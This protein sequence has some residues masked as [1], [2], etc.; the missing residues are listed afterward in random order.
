MYVQKLLIN[1]YHIIYIIKIYKILLGERSNDTPSPYEKI[2]QGTLVFLT[3]SAVK[4][5]P[6]ICLFEKKNHALSI[7]VNLYN[8][9][10]C[11][12]SHIH[13]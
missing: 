3:L 7:K 10:S 11:M 4:F 6:I 12:L 8:P 2:H 9:F 5:F 13:A 1:F